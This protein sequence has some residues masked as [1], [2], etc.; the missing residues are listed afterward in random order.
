MEKIY[1][2][3][4][5]GAGPAG[6]AAAIYA[7]RA[8]LTTILIEKK[9]DGGQIMSTSEIANYPGCVEDESGPSLIA[10]M[11]KQVE[12]FGVERLSDSI[13]GKDIEGEIKVLHGEKGDIKAKTIIVATGAFPRALGCE[14][15]KEFT[16]KGVSYCATCDG[17][18]FTDLEVFVVGGGDAAME[19]ALFLTKFVKKVTVIHRFDY[20]EAA[21]SIQEK[22]LNHPQFSFIWESAI[23]ELKG[24]DGLLNEIVV[25]S[26]KTGEVTTYKADED[27]GLM[28]CFVFIGFI[29]NSGLWKDVITEERGYLVTDE[30]M[31][32]NIPGVYVAGDIRKK[33]LRQVVTAVSDGA[34]AAVSAEKY[35][36]ENNH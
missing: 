28:G 15:E 5:V 18:F 9:R 21:P 31:H 10:K 22:V 19:E 34:L 35:I 32:T 11:S 23:K 6:L 27:D 30:T 1:D 3:A 12:S 26:L 14:G 29:P 17:A 13:I 2:V 4:V 33:T 16:G 36:E 20:L 24:E 8:K 7:G 25:E